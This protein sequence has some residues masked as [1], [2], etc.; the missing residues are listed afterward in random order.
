LHLAWGASLFVHGLVLIALAAPQHSLLREKNTRVM[1]VK[2]HIESP[3]RPASAPLV[4]RPPRPLAAP[5]VLNQ[6]ALTRPA[7]P[8]TS[9]QF[10]SVTSVTSAVVPTRGLALPATLAGGLA[11]GLA[12]AGHAFRAHTVSPAVSAE[13]YTLWLEQQRG[14]QE[15]LN[16]A[17][18]QLP[19]PQDAAAAQQPAFPD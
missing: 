7:A 10:T 1:A 6:T 17:A 2:L 11:G 12:G 16:R 8:A 18:V 15:A 9:A 19:P 4:T 3:P 5:G 14:G 13:A